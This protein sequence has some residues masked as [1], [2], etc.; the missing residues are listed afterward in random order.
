MYGV[1]ETWNIGEIQ[2]SFAVNLCIFSS[3]FLDQQTVLNSDMISY[4]HFT[5]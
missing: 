5:E 2:G 1:F 4:V 3:Q